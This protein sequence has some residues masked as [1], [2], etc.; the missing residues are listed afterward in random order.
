MRITSDPIQQSSPA[1]GPLHYH[2]LIFTRIVRNCS[3][4]MICITFYDRSLLIWYV[5]SLS[6]LCLSVVHSKAFLLSGSLGPTTSVMVPLICPTYSCIPWH[7]G[8]ESSFFPF[9]H[10]RCHHWTHW[11]V[12][13]R[14]ST[15][16]A[17][18]VILLSFLAVVRIP[19]TRIEC[20]V[21]LPAVWRWAKNTVCCLKLYLTLDW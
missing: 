8:P 7:R 13:G 4:E 21:P 18:P 6:S 5:K 3:F 12:N 2:N 20:S 11:L 10:L 9:H 14:S 17:V 15:R 16:F 1:W 19:K